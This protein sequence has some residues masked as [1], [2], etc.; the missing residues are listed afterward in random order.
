MWINTIS[1]INLKYILIL[2]LGFFVVFRTVAFVNLY[3]KKK[4]ALYLCGI[5][6]MY[7]GF[8]IF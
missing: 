3:D 8:V 5:G 6:L 1:K 2:A 7:S 4:G